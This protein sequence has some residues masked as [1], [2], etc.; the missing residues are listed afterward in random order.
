MKSRL[1]KKNYTITNQ[2]NS[3]IEITGEVPVDIVEQYRDAAFAAFAER[4]E[5]DGFR[6]GNAP[7]EAVMKKIGAIALLEEMAQRALTDIYFEIIQ[8]DKIDAIGR[9]NI[10]I[11]KIAENSPLGFKITT[12]VIPEI[13]L[14]DYKKIAK[15]KNK[16]EKA[17][18]VTEAEIDNAILELRKMRAHQDMH[19]QG[20][21]HHDHNHQNIEEKDLPEFTDEM[22]KSFG[23]FEN[24]ADFRIKLAENMKK[25]KEMRDRDA[26]RM[27]IVEGLVVASGIEVPEMLVEYEIDKIL[28]QMEYDVSMAGMKMEDYLQSINKTK[29]DMRNDFRDEAKK[30]SAMQLIINKIVTEEKLEPTEQEIDAEVAKIMEFYKNN[31]GVN[32]DQARAYVTTVLT[33]QKFFE[34]LDEQK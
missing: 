25:E 13:K 18:E 2:P 32:T 4:V 7:K 17:I 5:V 19:D 23:P 30:R 6:K 10:V 24:V 20:I 1:D 16:E 11:T 34:F 27:E 33:N 15:A 12:A 21:D 9:P 31:K 14:P 3:T 22:V 29:E 26:K 8:N 28:G